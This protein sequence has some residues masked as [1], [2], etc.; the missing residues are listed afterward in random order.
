MYSLVLGVSSLGGGC[1]GLTAPAI[2]NVFDKLSQP[3]KLRFGIINAGGTRTSKDLKYVSSLVSLAS[4][5]KE[6]AARTPYMSS[7][8]ALLQRVFSLTQLFLYC[9]K[10]LKL[11]Y[12]S[13]AA[14]HVIQKI[15]SSVHLCF[16]ATVS[17]CLFVCN[18]VNHSKYVQC[19]SYD[20]GWSV[21]GFVLFTGRT[22]RCV[23]AMG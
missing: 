11:R 1:D 12:Y 3:D 15:S 17:S 18:L 4:H 6:P 9:P 23:C 14:S 5:W 8:I 22:S 7:F 20:H 13:D 21:A 16:C 19:G 10:F 2:A